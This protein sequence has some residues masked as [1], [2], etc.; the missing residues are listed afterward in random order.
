MARELVCPNCGAFVPIDPILEP[1]GDGEASAILH[2]AEI[3]I[4]ATMSVDDIRGHAAG[5]LAAPGPDTPCFVAG[6]SVPTDV[7]NG[8]S[9][10]DDVL[11]DPGTSAAP[12]L[13]STTGSTSGV[14]VYD[15]P[16]P[17]V[18]LLKTSSSSEATQALSG[19]DLSPREAATTPTP[20]VE[21]ADQAPEGRGTSWPM[22]L[23][24][25]YASAMTLA[26]VYLL[27]LAPRRAAGPEPS[28]ADE[29]PGA[30]VASIPRDRLTT[31]G[32]PLR[33]GSLEW[34][35]LAVESGRV[36]LQGRGPDGKRREDK[37]QDGSLILRVR[38]RNLSQDDALAPL[39]PAFV[40]AP[41][42]GEPDSFIEVEGGEPIDVYPLAVQSEQSIAGQS[43]AVL[44]PGEERETI[45][46]SA[47]GA[48]DRARG[49]MTWRL[50]LRTAP[51]RTDLVGVRFHKADVR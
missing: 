19:L 36:R 14:I 3:I 35:P 9:S 38:F 47:P 26:C 33:V 1:T 11:N 44:R 4:P 13:A 15:E 12:S 48:V 24:G 5:W 22:L 45:I 46:P 20:V 41:D 50:R 28:A 49:P 34:T 42:R 43:F 16:P 25:S 21:R 37:G 31:L 8:R 51:D 30:V 40:R 6:D 23:L 39:D 27:W 7:S 18:D 17:G 2:T 10:S 29:R 32:K